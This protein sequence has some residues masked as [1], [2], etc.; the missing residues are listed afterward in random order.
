MIGKCDKCVSL[1]GVI[2]GMLLASIVHASEWT[3]KTT[4]SGFSSAVFQKSDSDTPFNGI[5]DVGVS[6]EGTF[7]GM[8]FGVNI[9]AHVNDKI[10]LASQ[11]LS[12]K[13]NNNYNTRVDWAF[14]SY[15]VL[16]DLTVRTG[17][18]KYPVGIAN[19][20]VSV[21]YAYP[22]I[23]PPALFYSLSSQGPQ[24]TR[25]AYTGGSVLWRKYVG[26]FNYSV[27]LF[28]GEVN[29]GNMVVRALKGITASVDW[30]D[31]VLIQMSSYQGTMD[32]DTML[33]MDGERHAAHVIG[34]KVDWGNVVGYAEYAD[35][36]MGDFKA[37]NGSAWYGS[38]GYRLGSFLPYANFSMYEKGKGAMVMMMPGVMKSAHNKQYLATLGVKYDIL[39]QTD[40]KLEVSR[41]RRSIGAG[42]Y[43]ES[44]GQADVDVNIFGVA[45]DVIF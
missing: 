29:L 9:N 38:L 33:A 25:E 7:S 3:E 6:D 17:K 26:D 31:R 22:W 5:G 45:I 34:I 24:V 21:G 36:D 27:D 4:L 19:E 42:L 43:D 15:Q 23:S 11:L 8:R 10:M 37:G 44:S 35:V 14:V 18:V 40:I 41:V 32:N 30:D 2:M 28:G 39:P 20:Y 1:T 16:D 13:E 12:S